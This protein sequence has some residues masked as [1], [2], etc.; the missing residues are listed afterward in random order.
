MLKF[1]RGGGGG[2]GKS[3]HVCL[4]VDRPPSLE[5]V[6][7]ITDDG[8]TLLLSVCLLRRAESLRV[9]TCS[10]KSTV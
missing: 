10:S 8:A 2:E 3:C 9:R 1:M 5:S 6:T 7:R 4:T